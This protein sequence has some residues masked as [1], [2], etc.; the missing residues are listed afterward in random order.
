MANSQSDSSADFQRQKTTFIRS[1]AH[2]KLRHSSPSS[3]FFSGTAASAGGGVHRA[4]PPYPNRQAL[5]HTGSGGGRITSSHHPRRPKLS[6]LEIPGRS[7]ENSAPNSTRINIV[8]SGTPRSAR[9]GLPP[10]PSSMRAPPT[11]NPLPQWSWIKN[12]APKGDR[13]AL[14]TPG[15][16]SQ[17]LGTS[18]QEQPNKPSPSVTFSLT[19]A[20]FTKTKMTISLPASPVANSCPESAHDRHVIDLHASDKPQE[21]NQMTRSRSVPGNAKS[22]SLRIVDSPRMIR[23][24]PVTPRP[25]PDEND[26]R[27]E[28]TEEANV[29]EGEV[30]G[31]DI[32]EEEAVCR[33]CL[34]ELGEGGET[35]KMEC[36]C[37]GELAL[38][39]KEC[40]IKWFSIKGN[41][42]CDVCKQDVQN[43]PVTL[44]RLQSTQVSH[45]RVANRVSHGGAL[46]YRMWQDVPVL[47]MVSILAY[48]CFL[49][50][51]LLSAMGPRA[52]ALSLPFSCLLGILS[53]LIACTMVT[54]TF[55]WTYASFQ[56]AIVVLFGHIFYTVLK[57]VSVF[58]ILLSSFSGFGVT[59][60]GN[61]LFV[62]YLRWRDRRNNRHE[63]R[64]NNNGSQQQSNEH[65]IVAERVEHTQQQEFVS[66]I[67]NRSVL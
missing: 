18:T 49:E 46:Q 61:T 9:S 1:R 17:E 45:R 15:T 59:V 48:F 51:L 53:S 66:Y 21:Q 34:V 44:L 47:V 14:L 6:S 38:A 37:K 24:I 27:V 12:E 10:R 4:T 42:I 31:E 43:L 22:R 29:D 7:L 62:E 19:R 65:S 33:I 40:A 39:H 3:S 8:P 54:R 32:P 58:S 13:T 26:T 52:L 28:I 63:R 35:L 11:A 2:G 41:K 20:L 55:I 50:Q 36:S 60:G 30:E 67:S 23:V 56:F 57:I 16:P 5:N 25:V 64:Q